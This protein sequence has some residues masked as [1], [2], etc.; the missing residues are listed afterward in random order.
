MDTMIL[1]KQRSKGHFGH[2][3]KELET[4]DTIMLKCDIV[5]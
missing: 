2:F 5:R 4:S 3:I 1:H